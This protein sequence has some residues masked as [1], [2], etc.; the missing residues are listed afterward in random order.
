VGEGGRGLETHVEGTCKADIKDGQTKTCAHMQENVE[1]TCARDMR[2]SA[3]H[4]LPLLRSKLIE[5]V[6]KFVFVTGH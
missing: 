5:I 1:E 3:T 6:G 4:T 2:A